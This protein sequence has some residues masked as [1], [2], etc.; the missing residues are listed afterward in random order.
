MWEWAYW[1]VFYVVRDAQYDWR[2]EQIATD[3]GMPERVQTHI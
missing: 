1:V 3:E 2:L